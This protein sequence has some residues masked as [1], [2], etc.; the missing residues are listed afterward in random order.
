MAAQGQVEFFAVDAATVITDFQ[1]A[2]TTLLNI[3]PDMR[4]SGIE[5]V[6][7]QFLNHRGWTFDHLTGGNLVYE[8]RG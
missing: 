6:F 4:G 5:T 1:P 3:Y 2:E 8:L 7:D